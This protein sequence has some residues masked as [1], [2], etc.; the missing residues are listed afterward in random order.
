MDFTRLVDGSITFYLRHML[1]YEVTE[2]IVNGKLSHHDIVP[3]RPILIYQDGVLLDKSKYDVN[4]NL[5]TIEF[6]EPIPPETVLTCQ[7]WYS[8]ISVVDAYRD[9]TLEP[10]IVVVDY[11]GDDEEPFE[12]GAGRKSVRCDIEIQ[13]YGINEGQRDD[14]VDSI[15]RALTYNVPIWD[16]NKNGYPVLHGGLWNK[17][18]NP[19][20]VVGWL[21]CDNRMSVRRNP[22]RSNDVIERGRAIINVYG[23]YTRS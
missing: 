22:L 9:D 1:A 15:K 12:L 17:E 23:E 18:F 21:Y 2:R 8:Y 19:K 5:G 3:T 7:Y 16:F 4:V 6:L 14:V 11:A 20:D 13:V 10:P